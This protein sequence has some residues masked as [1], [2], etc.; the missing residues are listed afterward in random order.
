V[1]QH[2]NLVP[3]AHTQQAA[4]SQSALACV[5]VRE[6]NL[7]LGS[8]LGEQ[9]EEREPS[10]HLADDDRTHTRVN[11]YLAT[12]TKTTQLGGRERKRGT[13]YICTSQFA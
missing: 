4:V 13:G 8:A 5:C 12:T 1:L 6:C 11:V 7:V 9:R 2:F 10:E 3:L